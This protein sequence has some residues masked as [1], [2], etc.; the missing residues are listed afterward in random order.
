MQFSSVYILNRDSITEVD[1]IRCECYITYSKCLYQK[2]WPFASLC[3]ESRT[4][5]GSLR[6]RLQKK[7]N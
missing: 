6:M 1:C 2:L 4:G 5:M 3:V 7:C